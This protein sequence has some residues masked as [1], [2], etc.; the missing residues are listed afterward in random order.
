MKV[1]GDSWEAEHRTECHSQAWWGRAQSGDTQQ[2][3]AGNV[4]Q[5]SGRQQTQAHGGR[6]STNQTGKM[7]RLSITI[8]QHRR[9]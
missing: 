1:N 5:Q 8:R 7:L 9:W 4:Q 2:A 3:P 6:Q